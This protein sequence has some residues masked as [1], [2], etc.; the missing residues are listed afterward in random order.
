LKES[1]YGKLLIDGRK[2]KL[3][4]TLDGRITDR[5]SS[6][7]TDCAPINPSS[8]RL[9]ERP[10]LRRTDPLLLIYSFQFRSAFRATTTPSQ[11]RA[12][13]T[14]PDHAQPATDMAPI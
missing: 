3:F 2:G 12:L 1:R 14:T 7:T 10:H 9:L 11:T 4:P 8:L 5:L 13:D 6:V